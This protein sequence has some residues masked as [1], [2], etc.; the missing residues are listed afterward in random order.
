MAADARHDVWVTGDVVIQDRTGLHARPAVKL[1]KLAKTFQSAI[2]IRG[3]GDSRWVDA[4]SPNAVMKLRAAHETV[5]AIRAS[6]EDAQTAVDELITLVQ[7]NFD[8]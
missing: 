4:K 6:G 5:L 2:E 7:R 1:T 8:G 3:E